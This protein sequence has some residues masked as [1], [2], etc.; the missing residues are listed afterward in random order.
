MNR[1]P[2]IYLAVP[3]FVLLSSGSCLE[4]VFG[5]A[6]LVVSSML[7]IVA[8]GL[9]WMRLYR[10]NAHP[11]LAV[12]C[13]LPFAVYFVMHQT[14]ALIFRE[15]PSWANLYALSWLGF[16]ATAIWSI[17][18]DSDSEDKPNSWRRDPV[19]LLL[20]P[21]IILFSISCFISY[22]TALT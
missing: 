13:I 8:W 17:L 12:L 11:E 3:L 14:G 22:Y 10:R 5:S 21:L 20:T 2:Y 15:H 16:A 4:S 6:V 9:V 19:F 18:P 1:R 7:I